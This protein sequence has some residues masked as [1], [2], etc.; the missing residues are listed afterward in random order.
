VVIHQPTQIKRLLAKLQN[1]GYAVKTE[2]LA[3]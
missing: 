2:P 3:A 1:L